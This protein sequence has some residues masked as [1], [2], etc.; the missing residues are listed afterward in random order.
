LHSDR[1]SLDEQRIVYNG[2]ELND[3]L[4]LVDYEIEDSSTV[5]LVLCQRGAAK[6]LTN[7][8]II[9]DPLL[10]YPMIADEARSM[11]QLLN[12]DQSK[13]LRVGAVIDHIVMK[14]EPGKPVILRLIGD[15]GEKTFDG[16]LEDDPKY[17]KY[18]KM[19]KVGLPM[20]AVKNA[21]QRDWI[22]PNIMDLDPMKS[23]ASQLNTD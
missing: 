17:R 21:L 20:G 7:G 16:P 10:A 8:D 4:S 2:N 23:I 11:A 12:D 6:I 18:F 1:H 5:R 9:S 3:E 13:G 22:N 15:K 19:L 14:L